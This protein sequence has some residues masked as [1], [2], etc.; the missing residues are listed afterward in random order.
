MGAMVRL[1]LRKQMV[2]SDKKPVILSPQLCCI[3]TKTQESR[4]VIQNIPTPFFL[5]SLD[6]QVV[7][8]IKST[9]AEIRALVSSAPSL[10]FVLLITMISPSCIPVEI[11]Q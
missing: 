7:V 11:Q 8:F 4:C 5:I 2:M 9:Y 1:V 10:S 3:Q 6:H